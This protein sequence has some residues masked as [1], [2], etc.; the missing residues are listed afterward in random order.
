MA[1][2]NKRLAGIATIAVGGKTYMLAADAAYSPSIVERETLKG[3]DSV[4][5]FKETPTA[6]YISA[7]LRDAGDLTVQDFNNMVDVNISLAL[8]NGKK[9]IG[10][11]MWCVN[12]QE[13]KATEGTFEVRFE[14]TS[15]TEA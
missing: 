9:I 1:T 7:T 12:A 2:P 6:P 14:G 13:V 15:V 8:A 10:S 5:G 3:M 11:H 4:H